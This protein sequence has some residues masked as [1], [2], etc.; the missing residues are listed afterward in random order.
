MIKYYPVVNV[1]KVFD[2][3]AQLNCDASWKAPAAQLEALSGDVRYIRRVRRA[4]CPPSVSLQSPIQ[5]IASP[6]RPVPQLPQV[7]LVHRQ[8]QGTVHLWTQEERIQNTLQ[9]T[10]ASRCGRKPRME[11]QL[12]TVTLH[13]TPHRLQTNV[14]WGTLRKC[15]KEF[16]FYYQILPTQRK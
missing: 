1:T 6:L 4:Q 5:V 12:N 3:D 2:F 15:F 13:Q 11:R 9:N 10:L 8:V 16:P 7:H 14:F